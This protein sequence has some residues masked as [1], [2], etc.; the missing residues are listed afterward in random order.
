MY[1]QATEIELKRIVQDS[2]P[3]GQRI[4]IQTNPKQ[5]DAKRGWVAYIMPSNVST[6]TETFSKVEARTNV[7]IRLVEVLS[8]KGT[9]SGNM[10][11]FTRA[12]HRNMKESELFFH[13]STFDIVYDTSLEGNYGA[14]ITVELTH[15]VE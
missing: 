15:G 10:L 9:P 8:T 3:S 12:I 5:V 13:L 1:D 14:E 2:L 6:S 11:P 4:Q 7:L